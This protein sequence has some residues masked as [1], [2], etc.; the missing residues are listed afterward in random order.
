MANVIRIVINESGG[1]TGIEYPM[2]LATYHCE[3]VA[4]YIS[5][6]FILI[7]T[8]IPPVRNLY[9]LIGSYAKTINRFSLINYTPL[10]VRFYHKFSH[11]A[12]R[13]VRYTR[14]KIA[15]YIQ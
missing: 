2:R 3:R 11:G 6:S 15:V 12:L 9:F 5:Y 7:Y 1:D 13:N 10:V 8:V 4:C 14:S